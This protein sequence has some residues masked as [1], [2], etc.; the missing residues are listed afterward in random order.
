[1]EEYYKEI[2][3]KAKKTQDERIFEL[4]YS[5]A[6][7]G[8]VTPL[9]MILDLKPRIALYTARLTE[10]HHKFPGMIKNRTWHDQ[11]G[12]VCSEYSIDIKELEQS[13]Q[14]D[15]QEDTTSMEEKIEQLELAV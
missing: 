10:L 1:M 2:T 7:A 3:T 14:D 5:R 12:T 11:D 9:W 15:I 8:L 13:R 6:L 4:I